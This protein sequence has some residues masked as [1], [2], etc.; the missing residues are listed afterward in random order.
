M[1]TT[2]ACGSG[3]VP[4]QRSNIRPQQRVAI[5]QLQFRQKHLPE[6][7]LSIAAI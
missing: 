6:L 1:K 3:Y 4:P 7:F 2:L 5:K